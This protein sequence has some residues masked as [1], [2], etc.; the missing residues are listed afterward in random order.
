MY[1]SLEDG[2][3][4]LL[5]DLWSARGETE[6]D[7]EKQKDPLIPE[8]AIYGET[9]Q[10]EL[11]DDVIMHELARWSRGHTLFYRIPVP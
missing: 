3:G 8:D 4:L 11:E 6:Q 10:T 5:C 2:M 9:R 1:C 7:R